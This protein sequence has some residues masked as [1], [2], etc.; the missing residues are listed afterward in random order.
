[1]IRKAKR[2]LKEVVEFIFPASEPIKS[3]QTSN[4]EVIEDWLTKNLN[5]MENAEELFIN[6]YV[7]KDSKTFDTASNFYTLEEAEFEEQQFNEDSRF[8]FYKRITVNL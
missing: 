7:D 5:T 6:I 8:Q 4:N 3:D 2:K 1:M